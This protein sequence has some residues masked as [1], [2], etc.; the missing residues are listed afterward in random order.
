VQK[1]YSIERNGYMIMHVGSL[2]I[3]KEMIVPSSG[4]HIESLRKAM[5]RIQLRYMVA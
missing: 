5:K 1:L 4:I 3:W 2:L